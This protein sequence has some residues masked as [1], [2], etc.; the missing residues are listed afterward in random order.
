MVPHQCVVCN[1]C[2]GCPCGLSLL[3]WTS[4]GRA[5]NLDRSAVVLFDEHVEKTFNRPAGVAAVVLEVLDLL[6]GNA[7]PAGQLCLRNLGRDAQLADILSGPFHKNRGTRFLLVAVFLAERC[8]IF[9]L[10]C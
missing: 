7:Q 10:L 1:A 5:Q 2:S 6:D 3:W 8:G 4:P 9:K